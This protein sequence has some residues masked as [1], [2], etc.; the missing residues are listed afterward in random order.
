MR[1]A[2]RDRSGARRAT[3]RCWTPSSASWPIARRAHARRNED[4]R[5][6]GRTWR[7]SSRAPKRPPLA[8]GGSPGHSGGEALSCG[9][10]AGPAS[11]RSRSTSRRSG[12][13]RRRRVALGGRHRAGVAV[14][15]GRGRVVVD[16]VGRR[17]AVER[18]GRVGRRG[19]GSASAVVSAVWAAWSVVVVVDCACGLRDGSADRR[20]AGRRRR[21]RRTTSSDS[22]AWDL[23]RL[24]C[25]A[26]RHAPSLPGEEMMRQARCRSCKETLLA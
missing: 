13:R 14:A 22:F 8:G 17:G 10:S 16:D 5:R 3:R 1:R 26:D 6:A 19:R 25:G 2:G 15:V 7:R 11:R 18:A 24:R 12:R 9:R 21:R 20:P 4:R 23:S